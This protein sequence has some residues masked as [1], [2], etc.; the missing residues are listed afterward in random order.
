M[1]NS[2]KEYICS[3]V[4]KLHKKEKITIGLILSEVPHLIKETSEGCI[5]DLNK[6]DESHI[7]NI[8]CYIKNRLEQ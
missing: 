7:H 5:V 8:Y 4:S 6:L 2:I 1:S 3:N